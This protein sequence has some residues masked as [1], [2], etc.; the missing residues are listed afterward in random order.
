MKEF[1]YFF[2]R[3]LTA[4]KIAMM[5]PAPRN[6]YPMKRSEPDTMPRII[7]NIPSMVWGDT[8]CSVLFCSLFSRNKEQYANNNKDKYRECDERE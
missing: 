6:A 7:N 5:T 1:F 8:S 4:S 3:F 2:C